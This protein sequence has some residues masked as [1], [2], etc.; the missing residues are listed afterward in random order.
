MIL[1]AK[2]KINTINESYQRQGGNVEVM[3][4][5]VYNSEKFW[6]KKL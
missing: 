3:K 5:F 2:P 1:E 4:F 6:K